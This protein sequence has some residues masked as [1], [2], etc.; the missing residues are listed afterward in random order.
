MMNYLA[1]SCWKRNSEIWAQKHRQ[2]RHDVDGEASKTI[3]DST[4]LLLY[5]LRQLVKYCVW[6]GKF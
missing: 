2:A 3:L 5:Q 4:V 1:M 6:R